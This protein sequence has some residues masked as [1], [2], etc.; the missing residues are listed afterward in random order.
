MLRIV[1]EVDD[2]TAGEAPELAEAASRDDS[3]EGERGDGARFQAKEIGDLLRG[4]DL[5]R[6]SREIAAPPV[7]S[8]GEGHGLTGRLELP[9][10]GRVLAGALFGVVL[11]VEDLVARDGVAEVEGDAVGDLGAGGHLRLLELREVRLGYPDR[12]GDGHLRQLATQAL[13]F[14]WGHCS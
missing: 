2:G 6:R 13:N 9:C 10:F 11:R 3:L 8:A 14:E 12:L 7:D 4:H 5:E 1:H